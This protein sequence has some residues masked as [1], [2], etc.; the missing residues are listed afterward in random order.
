LAAWINGVASHVLD[1][2]DTFPITVGYNMHPTV[3]ILPAILALGEKCNSPGSDI[4]TAYII[5]IEVESS[6]G[7]VMGLDTSELGWH[8][9]PVLGSIGATAASAKI[10]KLNAQQIRMALGI[11]SSLAGGLTRNF[12]TMTKP[13]H[14]GNAAKAGV[15]AT[16]LAKNGFTADT[17][18]MEGRFGFCNMFSGGK[19]S[20]PTIDKLDNSWDIVSTG[21]T[22]KPYP[23]CRGTHPSIDAMLYLRNKYQIPADQVASIKCKTRAG[24][25]R[26]LRYDRPKTGLEAKF[27][28]QYCVAA[29]LLRG[30][31]L[32]EDFTNEK[33]N[34]VSIQ[35]LIPK[36]DYL[37]PKE[38]EKEHSLTQEVVVK[39]NSGTEYAHKVTM[40]KGEPGNP[41]TDEELRA[42]FTDCAHI[43]LSQTKIEQVLNMLTD[44]ESIDNI[45]R[46][47]EL[48]TY[49]T[50]ERRSLDLK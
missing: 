13:L 44:L 42:K 23:C 25:R 21:I 10:L 7:S 40:P 4:L 32:L 27:S 5:G 30:K 46:L 45:S 39:L 43:Y 50:G 48:L 24:T 31:V 26:I 1:Y 9:T 8:P 36:I 11:A 28:I 38:L 3:P 20:E 33:V 18:L 19:V 16:L 37:H 35:E 47:M 49:K 14:V 15:V 17:S 34:E 2:D 22:F 29:A 12:G 6:L 41:P